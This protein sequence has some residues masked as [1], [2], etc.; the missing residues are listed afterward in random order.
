MHI[1]IKSYDII[2]CIFEMKS[3]NSHHCVL[4]LMCN[5]TPGY[6][7]EVLECVSTIHGILFPIP[8]VQ[9]IFS[10]GR[11]FNTL[12]KV[13]LANNFEIPAWFSRRMHQ[14]Q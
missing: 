14:V 10:N 7:N 11:L 5:N 1:Y 13:L 12:E 2:L 8:S 9:H 3:V 6:E 4:A